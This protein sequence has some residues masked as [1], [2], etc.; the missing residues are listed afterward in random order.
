MRDLAH[1]SRPRA[2]CNSLAQ[3]WPSLAQSGLRRAKAGANPEVADSDR[4]PLT[5]Q[6]ATRSAHWRNDSG[7]PGERQKRPLA[8]HG[9]LLHLGPQ[10]GFIAS[11]TR[12]ERASLLEALRIGNRA[13]TRPKKRQAPCTA[14]TP[15][16]PSHHSASALKRRL[17]APS[18]L[19]L[20]RRIASSL[21]IFAGLPLTEPS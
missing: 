20:H 12:V 9:G 11:Y 8:L 5:Q 6:A 15:T 2:A 7:C 19:L 21:G 18:R 1:T 14:D 3:A 4:T 17:K 13:K 10:K 16:R